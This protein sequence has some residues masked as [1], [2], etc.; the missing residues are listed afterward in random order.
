[1]ILNSNRLRTF[2]NAHLEIVTFV[3]AKLGLRIRDSKPSETGARGLADPKDVD[4][5]NS[6]ASGTGKGSSSPPDGRFQ[7]GGAHVQ[8]DCHVHV[9]P[10]T[11]NGKK[12][13]RVSHGP[14]VLTKVRARNIREADNPEENPL[15]PKCE[16]APTREKLRTQVHLVLKN[17]QKQR[18]VHRHKNLHNRIVRTI[19]PL[20]IPRLTMAGAITNGMR[21]GTRLPGMNVGNKPMTIPQADSLSLGSLDLGAM[22]SPKRFEWVNMNLDTRDGRFYRTASGEC[23][24][25]GRAWQLQSDD[26]NGWRRSL[27]G[28]LTGEHQV[29]CSVGGFACKRHQDFYLRSDGGFLKPAQRKNGQEE[30]THFERWVNWCGRT[31]LIP[32]Y[33]EDNIFNFELS[34]EMK[35]TENSIVNNIQQPR[36]E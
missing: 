16:K 13:S 12:S 2:V 19:L 8:R 7:C 20:T 31:Q 17:S 30:R 4:A 9:T 18:Q 35:S 24:L 11:S 26:E 3:E 33:I 5:T 25:E 10:R 29:L 14:R 22:S 15:V 6:P 34:K 36:N 1:M 28:R 32:V 21:T 23:I 27:H